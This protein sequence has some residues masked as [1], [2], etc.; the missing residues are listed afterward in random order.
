M[1]QFQ[2]ASRIPTIARTTALAL[3][4]VGAAACGPGPA[5]EGWGADPHVDIRIGSSAPAGGALVVEYDFSREVAVGSPQCIGGAGPECSGGIVLR[6]GEAPGFAPQRDDDPAESI[7]PLVAGTRVHLELTASS[8]AASYFISG[9]SLSSV[10]D[11]VLLGEA[12]D[13]LHVHGDWQV[14]LPGGTEPEDD[15]FL[16]FK[17]TTDSPLYTD[18]DE[19]VVTLHVGDED[20]HGEHEDEHGDEHE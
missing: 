3:T 13:G 1:I 2:T 17:L 11:S 10:G 12:L 8:P 20:E 19:F 6:S 9:T 4:L 18:S 15:Y 16:G 5:P 14:V 7:F